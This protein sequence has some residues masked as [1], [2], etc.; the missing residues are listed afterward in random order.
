MKLYWVSCLVQYEGKSRHIGMLDPC[1]SME[2]AIEIIKRT[3]E[4]YEVLSA[5]IDT[6]DD[7]G[8]KHIEFHECYVDTV[9]NIKQY[10]ET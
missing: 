4:N 3:R 8:N 7:D 1:L 5:W 2:K 10:K 6:F 9:G